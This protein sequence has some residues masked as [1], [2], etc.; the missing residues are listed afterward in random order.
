[1]VSLALCLM[2]WILCNCMSNFSI[3]EYLCISCINLIVRQFIAPVSQPH[4]N[5]INLAWNFHQLLSSR[6][7]P[8]FS[9]NLNLSVNVNKPFLSV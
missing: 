7:N 8:F 5:G 4:E 1:M 3:Q 6:G 9:L 2:M